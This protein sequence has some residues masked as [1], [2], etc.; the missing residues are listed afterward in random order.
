MNRDGQIRGLLERFTP[1]RLI[2]LGTG[3][4][5]FALMAAEMGWRVTATDARPRDWPYH[6]RITWWVIDV[7]DTPVSGYDLILCAGLFYHLEYEDQ[8][9][10]LAK[11][12]GTPVILDTHVS[13]HPGEAVQPEAGITGRVYI[14]GPQDHPWSSWGNKQSFWPDL[15]SLH[16]MAQRFGYTME[17]CQPWPGEDRATFMWMPE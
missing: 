10:L 2:D 14:E 9:K 17:T 15:P 13:I 11:C 5:L 3:D 12:S 1:G 8:V 4:G 7:R 16:R 6:E